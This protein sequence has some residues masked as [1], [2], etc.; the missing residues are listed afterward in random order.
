MIFH[1][2]TGAGNNFLIA[3]AREFD[4]SMIT[5]G[6]T[7]S[8]LCSEHHTDGLM[9]LQRSG[10]TDFRM[11]FFNPDG[12]GG[13]M[14]GNGGRCIVA[15]A[16]DLGIIG[17]S[18][19]FKAPDG[20]HEAEIIE[21]DGQVKTVR[22]KMIDVREIEKYRDGV[23]LN[24]GTR[25]FVRMVDDIN[26][27][28]VE[29]Q[30]REIRHRPVF[31][32]EGTNVNFV[33]LRSNRLYV[34]TYEKGVERETLACGTGIV[35]SAIAAHDMGVEPSS[36]DWARLKYEVV[37]RRGDRLSVDFVPGGATGLRAYSV[38]LTG[39]AEKLEELDISL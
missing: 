19:R 16:A 36:H 30:G 37:A 27:V 33:Q 28:D 17:N 20:V 34:R 18:C 9:V 39:P 2:Y 22:L 10:S 3:D 4:S 23:F 31:A 26:A 25:H 8:Q 24:T 5:A 6:D 12:S 11:L 1:H 14:C 7:I 29:A 38:Y 15:F 35:A 21:D 13:M 32:P